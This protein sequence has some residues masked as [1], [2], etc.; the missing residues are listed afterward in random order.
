[1]NVEEYLEETGINL[2]QLS[3]EAKVSYEILR[4][5]VR[6]GGPIGLKVATKLNA[7]DRR[8]SVS[9]ILGIPDESKGAA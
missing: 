8:L 3:Q 1:M 7:F 9:E 4:K 2:H 5:H 6:A